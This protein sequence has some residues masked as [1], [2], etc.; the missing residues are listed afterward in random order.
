MNN[1]VE[2]KSVFGCSDE[3]VSLEFRNDDNSLEQ[4]LWKIGVLQSHL[5]ELKTRFKKVHDENAKD[6]YSAA[7][8]NSNDVSTSA[9]NDVSTNGREKLVQVS[10]VASQLMPK[11]NRRDMLTT[12]SGILTHGEDTDFIDIIECNDKLQ[13][14]TSSEKVSC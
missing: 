3:P 5:G 10:T 8:M 13:I 2:G 11:C 4:I 14:G 9:Q 6:I 1:R 7:A 12:E